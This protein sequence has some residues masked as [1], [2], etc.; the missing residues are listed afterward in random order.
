MSAYEKRAPRQSSGDYDA[1]TP[2]RGSTTPR[3]VSST[4][5][6]RFSGHSPS[7]SAMSPSGGSTLYVSGMGSQQR[8]RAT[9]TGSHMFR[10]TTS[11]GDAHIKDCSMR[12]T[13]G[14]YQGQRSTMGAQGTAAFRSKSPSD[15]DSHMRSL[16]SSTYASPRSTGSRS[17]GRQGQLPSA[18]FRSA[19]PTACAHIQAMPKPT[20][21]SYNG[22]RPS[23]RGGAT[24]QFRST[25]SIA[26][27]HIK[28]SPKMHDSVVVTPRGSTRG[29][30]TAQFRSTT[31]IADAHIK[32]MPKMTDV[33]VAY[34]D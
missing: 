10:S 7:Q 33:V 1:T 14:P 31:S 21:A 23:S 25:T 20:D 29:G 4:P 8:R 19:S 28:A 13:P 22:A 34:R 9:E 2:N 12:V 17:P 5:R 11:V 30:A 3:G 16:M 15:R 26:D 18:S 32:A 27:A 24:A 6:S